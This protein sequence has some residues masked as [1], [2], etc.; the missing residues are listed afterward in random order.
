MQ[1]QRR[2]V[3]PVP[4]VNAPVAGPKAFIRDVLADLRQG[5][6]G[7]ATLRV[8]TFWGVRYVVAQS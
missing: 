3:F 1:Q 6:S 8:L 2:I 5:E 4:V 7:R